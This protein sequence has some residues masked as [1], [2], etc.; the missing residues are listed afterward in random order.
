MPWLE[1]R[2]NGQFHI[3]LRYGGRKLKKALRTSDA[4]SAEA[5]LLQLEENLRLLE[6]GRI[7]LPEDADLVDFLLSDG[8]L[9]GR[10]SA[11]QS[12]RTLGQFGEA[13][14]KSIPDGSLEPSTVQGMQIHLKHLYR[15]LGKSLVVATLSLEDLQRYVDSRAKGRGQ[16]GQRL[17]PAVSVPPNTSSC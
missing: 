17:S 10:L 12:I 16:R 4:R 7:E 6:K 2:P 8:K 13:F 3:A 1:Q 15:V 14:L 9:N 5:R 11:R